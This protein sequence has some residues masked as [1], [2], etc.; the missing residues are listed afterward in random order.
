MRRLLPISLMILALLVSSWGVHRNEAV[1]A[2]SQTK[3]KLDEVKNEKKQTKEDLKAVEAKLEQHKK[4]LAQVDEKLSAYIQE[5]NRLNNE[6]AA[7]EKE[8]KAVEQKLKKKLQRLYLQ[9]EN[10]YL[11]QILAADTFSDFLNRFQLI[12]IIVKQDVNDFK[13]YDEIKQKFEDDKAKIIKAKEEQEKLL[14]ESKQRVDA[15]N[16]EMAKYKEEL[17][18]LEKEEEKLMGQF[19]FAGGGVLGY[20]STPGKTY[21]NYGQNRGSHIHAGV[22]IPRPIGTP[23]YASEDGVVK[24]VRYDAG[25]YAW[26]IIVRHDNG[27]ETLYAHMYSYQVKVSTGQRVSRGQVIGAVGN[28]GRS[29]GPHLHYEVHKNGQPV[30]P[31]PYIS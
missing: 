18:Q 7:N 17:K 24:S 2:T 23:I 14:K 10:E 1:A 22:D 31:K 9:G 28:A 11:A 26:Y 15:M 13:R 3:Q 5:V 8:L 12:R 4:D 29:S 19:G 25:G 27:L 16:K 6:L 21:W 30:N 20:P